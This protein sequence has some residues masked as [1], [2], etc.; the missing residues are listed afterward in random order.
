MES[1]T[2]TEKYTFEEAL[3][4]LEAV[5]RELE[6]GKLP[7]EKALEVFEKGISLSSFCH[8]QLEAAEQRI[9]VLIT[10]ETGEPVLK[11]VPSL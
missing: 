1:S 2:G 7:L 6:S 3:A 8:R 5:V 9:S 10:S 4:G 11:E